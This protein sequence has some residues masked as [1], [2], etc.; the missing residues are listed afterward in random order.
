[1]LVGAVLTWFPCPAAAQNF[2][3]L[4]DTNLR[5]AYFFRH[6]QFTT[7]TSSNV[8]DSRAALGT[9]T[10]DGAGRYGLTGFQTINNFAAINLAINGTYALAPAGDITLTNPQRPNFSMNGRAGVEAILAST[11]ESGDNTFDLFVAVPAPTA[12]QPAG[13]F[14][15]SGNYF[16]ASLELP[17]GGGTAVR[18]ALTSATSTGNGAFSCIATGHAANANNGAISTQALSGL[19]YAIAPDGSGTASFGSASNNLNGTK[20]IYVSQSGNVI[21]GGSL[22]P[23]SQDLLI[24]VKAYAGTPAGTS[25]SGLYWQG[26]LRLDIKQKSTQAYA[27]SLNGF[28][29]LGRAVF[30]D[31]LHQIGISP[32]Y[33]FTGE[34]D[35]VVNPAGSFPNGT[36]AL[37]FDLLGLGANGAALVDAGLSSF[38]PSGYSIDLAIQAPTLTGTGVYVNPQGIVNA[39][40]LAPVGQSISPG[41]FVSIFGAGLAA[42]QMAAV[43][44]YPLTLGGVA[45]TVNGAAAPVYFVSAGQ[46]NFVVPNGATGNSATVAV[47]NNGVASN[48][49][50]VPLQ[51]TSPGIFSVDGSGT[52][53]GMVT[54]ASGVLVNAKN[55]AKKGETVTI[56]VA[57]LGAVTPQPADGVP[58]AA[59]PLS[60]IN[61]SVTVTIGGQAVTIAFAGLAPGF[62]GLYQLNVT[63]PATLSGSGSLPLAIETADTFS[64]QVNIQVQ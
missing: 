39:A 61:T 22:L 63:I 29:A 7:D 25:I 17:G 62:P 64:D 49:V 21:L 40:S 2:P 55:P 38:D 47:T 33:D 16:I 53:D 52:G 18:S 45:V 42:Q 5:G 11:T 14:S 19:T 32:G 15:F 3:A 60:N 23:G 54:H 24:G 51:N 56:Y 12:T 46:V 13:S 34:N 48:T 36:L 8:I 26:G 31:R 10:F 28:S 57:G 4:T 6:L 50:A 41:E 37:G 20:N 1:M 9:I 43:P 30:A 59:N 58:G 27:G 44:P 35:I